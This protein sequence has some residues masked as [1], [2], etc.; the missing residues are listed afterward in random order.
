MARSRAVHRPVR[1]RPDPQRADSDPDPSLVAW[2]TFDDGVGTVAQ[3]ASGHQNSAAIVKW[4]LGRRTCGHRVAHGRRQRRHRDCPGFRQSPFANRRNHRDGLDLSHCETQCRGDQSWVSH[5]VLR[6]PRCTV[7]VAIRARERP[8]DGVLRRS[9][10]RGKAR[11]VD[12][13][14]GDL[15]RL[16]RALVCGRRRGL[17]QV[18]VG[19]NQEHRRLPLRSRATWTGPVGSSTRSPAAWT[20]FEST[21]ALYLPKKSGRPPDSSTDRSRARPAASCLRATAE[22]RF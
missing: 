19:S 17:Q 6:L 1:L 10:I 22:S 9:E 3:D 18:D 11:S 21:T 15:Q 8:H 7:Q 20:T 2:W 4:R 5:A 14:R 13:P 12:P 16:G